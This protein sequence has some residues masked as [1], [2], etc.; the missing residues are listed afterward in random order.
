[1]AGDDPAPRP[2]R[3]VPGGRRAVGTVLVL[4]VVVTLLRTLVLD[5]VRVSSASMWPSVC[6]GD[7][8]L[9]SKL[10]AGQ[11]VH[12]D[13]LVVFRSPVDG[14]RTL[15]RVVALA[16]QSVEVRDALLYV[17]GRLAEEEYVDHATVDGTFFGPTVVADDAVFVMGDERERSIDSRDYGPVPRSRVE[18]KVLVRLWSSC[19]GEDAPR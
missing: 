6:T 18:G 5:T 2:R 19:R 3:R 14:Q 12:R 9:V 11:G 4:L 7:R 10:R 16:G 13:D 15:K 17:D 8:L 1:M